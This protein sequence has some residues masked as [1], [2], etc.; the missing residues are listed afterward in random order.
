[1]IRQEKK[2]KKE[3][4]RKKKRYELDEVW[5]LPAEKGK[6][7]AFRPRSND[8]HTDDHNGDE[9]AKVRGRSNASKTFILSRRRSIP[10]TAKY[11]LLAARACS[12]LIGNHNSN[13]RPSSKETFN[14]NR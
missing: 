6:E 4:K 14:T 5:R 7:I 3:K 11:V 12:I 10:A 1:M 2:E 8:Y 9:H 13:W